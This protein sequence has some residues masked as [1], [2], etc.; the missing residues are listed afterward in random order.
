MNPTDGVNLAGA[1]SLGERVTPGMA[2]VAWLAE[3][4]G[5]LGQLADLMRGAARGTGSVAVVS[6]AAGMGKSAL[7]A[8]VR[9]DAARAG[10]MAM[11][12]SC[13]AAEAGLAYGVMSQLLSREPT[14]VTD[15][16]RTGPAAAAA[17]SFYSV[18]AG[19][20][21]RQPVVLTVDDVQFAD[22]D[23]VLCLSYLMR[24]VSQLRIMIVFSQPD[25][26][27]WPLTPFQAELARDPRC[28]VIR[29]APLTA[30]GVTLIAKAVRDDADAVLGSRL[31][32]ISGGNPLL[33]HALLADYLEP[34]P[35][36]WHAVLS[37]LRSMDAVPQRIAAALAVLG[38]ASAG[39]SGAN[40][41]R[42]VG[43]GAEILEPGLEALRGARLIDGDRRFRHPCARSAILASLE[44]GV[45]A[46]LHA[47]AAEIAFRTGRPA[48]DV[49]RHLRASTCGAPWAVSVLEEAADAAIS[50]GR[51]N[52]AIE[53]LRLAAVGCADRQ[54]G[55]AIRTRLIR[56]EWQINPGIPAAELTELA[57][58]LDRGCLRGQDMVVLA[59]ALLWHG[60][61]SEAR[62]I[63]RQL[64]D[65]VDGRPHHELA[66]TAAEIKALMPWLRCTYPPV[67]TDC[68]PVPGGRFPPPAVTVSRRQEAASALAA[69]LAEGPDAARPAALERI[70]RYSQL[71]DISMDAE[72]C[73]LLAM[74]YSARVDDA[75]RWIDMLSAEATARNAPSRQARLAAIRAEIGLRRGNLPE[76]ADLGQT[77]LR[78]VPPSGWGVA[79]GA[80]LSVAMLALTAMGRLGDAADLARQHLPEAA[81]GTRHALP[82]LF[83]RGHHQLAIGDAAAALRDF[84]MV[85]ELMHS[86][87]LD[88]PVLVSWR[89]GAAEALLRLGHKARARALVTDHLDRPRLLSSRERGAGQRLLAMTAEPGGRQQLLRQAAETLQEA[90]DQYEL[91]RTLA[92]LATAHHRAGEPRRARTVRQQALKLAEE[93]QAEPLIRR[94]TAG[95]QAASRTE[96]TVL[97]QAERRVADLAAIGYTN[98][99][100]SDRLFITVSTVEQHL[101]R[102]YRKLDLSG[103]ADLSAHFRDRAG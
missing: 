68:P 94:L 45:K 10:A 36:Y 61:T 39:S 6:G 41:C 82:Y 92:A 70:L 13:C 74:L 15:G 42:L 64:G 95:E 52:A 30:V 54:R 43:V 48:E 96:P 79:I 3:R 80:P 35:A 93:C 58:E 77:A 23:S 63:L 67:L 31:H 88:S 14:T 50:D 27:W 47:R 44:P 25:T 29:L 22:P 26:A 9:Q 91:C 98:L 62:S 19:I 103:R 57:V 75:A 40:L 87:E 37:C 76:A 7:L 90:G 33:V 69:V 99:E 78:L 86:W 17:D 55:T 83:A 28:Q 4:D 24:R 101:T 16:D 84:Q 66:E 20:T 46:E 34:G 65:V 102:V 59:K 8:A 38:D 53:Y 73:A 56:A 18:L 89:L 5:E 51:L 60:Q 49:A 12:A 11:S 1:V 85:G 21:Q 100:I 32:E 72:E 81:L 97:S 2:E 71:R